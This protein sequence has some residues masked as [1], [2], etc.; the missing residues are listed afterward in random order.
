MMFPN[1][2]LFFF[3]PEKENVLSHAPKL[4]FRFIYLQSYTSTFDGVT[5][6]RATNRLWLL[7]SD[8]MW[9]ACLVITV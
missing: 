7:G 4:D 8:M 2:V 5:L 1:L 9:W 3:N 6:F